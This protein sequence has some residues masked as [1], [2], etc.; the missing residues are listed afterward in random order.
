MK[1]DD[2]LKYVDRITKA[3]M[4]IAVATAVIYFFIYLIN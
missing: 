2:Y 1:N 4:I 3:M